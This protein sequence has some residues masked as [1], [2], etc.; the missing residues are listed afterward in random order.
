MQA[1]I[2]PRYTDTARQLA[3]RLHD[4]DRSFVMVGKLCGRNDGNRHNFCIRYLGPDIA[5]MIQVLH[6]GVDHDKRGYNPIGVHW[7]LLDAIAGGGT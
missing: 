6:H 1:T 7:L 5:L 3:T 4:L 2:E